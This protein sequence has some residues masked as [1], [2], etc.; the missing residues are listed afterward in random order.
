MVEESNIPRSHPRY[1]SLLKREKL[2]AGFKKGIV[3]NAG[4]IAHGRGETFDYF[5]GEKSQEFAIEA[6]KAAVAALKLAVNPVISINGNVAALVPDEIIE[7]SKIVNAKLELNLFY[8]TDERV[9]KIEELFWEKGVNL[10]GVE[11][12]AKIPGLD[13]KRALCSRAGI[14]SADAVLIP[15][16]DGDRAEA[17]KKMGKRIIAIDLNPLSRTAQVSD[18]TIVNELTRAV[19]EMVELSKKITNLENILQNYNNKKNLSKSLIFI[20][21]R[22]EHLATLV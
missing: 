11:P 8:R 19:Q 16:E 3:S 20:K 5:L 18:I 21:E 10:L 2:I 17:L 7:L 4:L 13:H 22:L 12:D 1:D 15:L 9:K 6:E 14:Y